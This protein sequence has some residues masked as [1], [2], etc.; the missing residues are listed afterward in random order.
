M[1]DVLTSASAVIEAMTFAIAAG[2]NVS[3]GLHARVATLMATIPARKGISDRMDDSAQN[4]Q[5]NWEHC[6]LDMG[7]WIWGLF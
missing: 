2:G 3:E 1:Q 7:S 5:P 6:A 4:V